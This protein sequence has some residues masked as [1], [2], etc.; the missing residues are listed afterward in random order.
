LDRSLTVA[1]QDAVV[2]VVQAWLS[3][4]LA[5]THGVGDEPDRP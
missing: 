3:E 1:Q 2:E 4:M 5:G